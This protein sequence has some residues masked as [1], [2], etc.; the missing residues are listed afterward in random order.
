MGVRAGEGPIR[1]RARVILLT[2]RGRLR[3]PVFAAARLRWPSPLG[4]L[5]ATGAKRTAVLRLLR[6]VLSC[7]EQFADLR[8][9]WLTV[10]EGRGKAA[11]AANW[12]LTAEAVQARGEGRPYRGREARR[13]PDGAM[14]RWCSP[15]MRGRT[16]RCS[17]TAKQR[18][19]LLGGPVVV[20]AVVALGACPALPCPAGRLPGWQPGQHDVTGTAARPTTQLR[21]HL[22]ACTPRA[23][24]ASASRLL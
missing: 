6:D 16:G 17:P 8:A 1:G 7:G 10:G 21:P 3:H 20:A 5:A 14:E 13:S 12:R 2:W 23:D 11:R 4:I 22:P 18:I 24:L 9:I 19:A 15:G